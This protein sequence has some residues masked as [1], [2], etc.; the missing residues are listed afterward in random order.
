[1]RKPARHAPRPVLPTRPMLS[2]P[3]VDK[4]PPPPFRYRPPQRPAPQPTIKHANGNTWILPI[5]AD[6]PPQP[7]AGGKGVRPGRATA[8]QVADDGLTFTLTLRSGT[9]F[10]DGSPIPAGDVKWTL[11]R[12]R[13]PKNGIWSFT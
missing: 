10:S 11:D 3:M 7:P 5:H 6:T 12:A 1:M 13:N 4:K 2:W 9:R 8:Y